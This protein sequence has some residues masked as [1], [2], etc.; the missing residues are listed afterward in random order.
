MEDV[1]AAP[2]GGRPLS[3]DYTNANMQNGFFEGYTKNIDVTNLFFSNVHGE[4][5]HAA[6]SYPG[7][8]QD[9]KPAQVSGPMTT[10]LLYEN[11]PTA[12]AIL[13]D[14]AFVAST[15]AT[16]GK[17][18]RSQRSTESK[19]V[20]ERLFLGAIDTVLQNGDAQ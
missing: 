7:S 10:K 1:F 14:R 4:I 20:P 11:A 12:L 2:D 9:N 15:K 3:A 6:T 5:T 17:I 18:V 8:W 13:R 16:N 19:N